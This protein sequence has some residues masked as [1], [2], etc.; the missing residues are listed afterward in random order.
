MKFGYVFAK[1][2]R[3]TLKKFLGNRSKRFANTTRRFYD[4]R[5]FQ[6]L[7][8]NLKKIHTYSDKLTNQFWLKKVTLYVFLLKI[9]Y[10]TNLL[11][12]FEHY[13]YVKSM[14]SD[15]VQLLNSAAV[16]LIGE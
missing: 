7:E 3:T 16:G 1:I 14:F 5:N 8:K 4:K 15:S 2:L 10:F 13:L 6:K 11:I 9:F 12:T